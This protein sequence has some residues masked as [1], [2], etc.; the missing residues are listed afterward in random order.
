MVVGRRRA[1]PGEAGKVTT[2]VSVTK[3]AQMLNTTPF[4]V[5]EL[6]RTG[7]LACGDIEGVMVIPVA[8]VHD[9]AKRRALTGDARAG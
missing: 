5:M 4:H 7:E 2:L 1:L 8:A 3:A 6:C 9:Y